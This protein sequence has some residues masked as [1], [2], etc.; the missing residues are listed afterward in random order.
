MGKIKHGGTANGKRERLYVI[1]QDMK[2]RC[3]NINNA[4][5][6][7]YGGRGIKVC[8]E[9]IND[10]SC[11]RDWAYNTGYCENAAMYKCTLDRIDNNGNYSPNNCRWV[12]MK[13]QNNNRKNVRQFIYNGESHTLRE[14]CDILN[15]SFRAVDMRLQRGWSVEEALSRPIKEKKKSCES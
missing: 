12:D 8:D 7:Y 5:Y 9:W 15:M 14:W 4:H 3:Q 2:D 13:A 6:S 11:F 10:Y 1:W